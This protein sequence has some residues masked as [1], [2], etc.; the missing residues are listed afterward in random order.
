MAYIEVNGARLF[1]RLLGRRRS[2]K[3]PVVLIHG[4]T[5][6]G[7]SNW[8]LAAPLLAQTYT[9]IVPDCRGHGRSSNP[10]NSYSFVEMA[11][12]VAGLV[13]AL[14]YERAHIIGHSNG[15]N[16]ALVTLLEHPEV[17]QSAVLQAANAY[18]SPD[19]VE[20]E[21]AVFDP[22]HVA[23]EDPGW[24]RE[25]IRL[26]GPTHGR[27]YWR[28]LLSLT[29]QAII[30]EPNYTPKDLAAVRRPTLVVQGEHDRVNAPARHA[31]FIAEHIPDAEL[32]IPEGVGHTVHDERLFEW[33]TR[34]VDFLERRGD[35]ANDALYR[36]RREQYP[37]EREAIFELRARPSGRRNDYHLIGRVSYVEQLDRARSE[38]PVRARAEDQ[39][40]VLL[41]DETEWALAKRSVTNLRR[42]P[43][44]LAERVSQILMGEA[45]RILEQN[46]TWSWVRL[47]RDGYM[48]W[49]PSVALQSFSP[50]QVQA[51]LQRSDT[52]VCAELAPTFEAPETKSIAARVGRL[53]FGVVLPQVEA[54]Q[55]WTALQLPDGA[56]WWLEAQAVLPAALRPKP[57]AE[58]I[59]QALAMIQR[60]VGIPY[61]WGG[62]SPYGYDCSGLAQTFWAYLGVS[63]LRDADQQMRAAQAVTGEA[64]PGDL[65]FF[66]EK[67]SSGYRPISHVAISLGG[68]GMIHANG[69]AGGISYNSLE[70]AS[71]RYRA[72]LKEN[73]AGV[74]RFPAGDLGL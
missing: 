43:R 31:Q 14:G 41:N 53:P 4:S 28:S 15:G 74:G 29:L 5:G 10:H 13:R 61:L 63:I 6:T 66:G 17:V 30:S 71:P 7:N 22:E 47:E 27:D 59:Q 50:E 32:W 49:T 24:M 37:D 16:L 19:L 46:E 23:R 44:M 36:L 56:V 18:V 48:G 25:M 65:L 60:F 26:H 68:A 73:L 33:V 70:P 34:V 69:A 38:L 54:R 62:R 42:E 20:K 40:Q 8:R 1:Y 51:Y 11:D 57:D 67:D 39:V 72:W 3:A 9:V 12:D 52:L 21:P 58:G 35:E 2:K 45:V 64:Q 55:G